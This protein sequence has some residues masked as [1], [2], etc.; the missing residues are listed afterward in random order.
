MFT[1]G[2][3][4]KTQKTPMSEIDKAKVYRNNYLERCELSLM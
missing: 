1:N 2:F 3:V 4:K